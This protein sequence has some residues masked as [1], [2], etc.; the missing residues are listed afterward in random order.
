MQKVR[1]SHG[2]VVV[3]AAGKQHTEAGRQVCGAPLNS[4]QR[5]KIYLRRSF[6][7]GSRAA[8]LFFVN[9]LPFFKHTYFEDFI[10]CQLFFEFSSVLH[11]S[12]KRVWS[13]WQFVCFEIILSRKLFVFEDVYEAF[14]EDHNHL[15]IISF[16]KQSF[17]VPIWRIWIQICSVLTIRHFRTWAIRLCII[18]KKIRFFLAELPTYIDIQI[19]IQ[20]RPTRYFVKV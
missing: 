1:V 13:Y 19:K 12:I 11:F 5:V 3:V 14:F 17:E 7:S 10:G 4:W 16:Q 18:Q 8:Q 6:H 20:G 2:C 9:I 15:C